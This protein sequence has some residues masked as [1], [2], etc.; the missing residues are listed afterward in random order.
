[1]RINLVLHLTNVKKRFSS[2][3]TLAFHGKTCL[4]RKCYRCEVFN[5]KFAL[6]KQL[7]DH[8]RKYHTSLQCDYCDITISSDK[9]MKR[10]V[11]LK[12]RGLPPSRARALEVD[13]LKVPKTINSFD[14]DK[15]E[16][17]FY[18]KVL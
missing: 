8:K 1:M 14:R 16:K 18:D 15:C 17:T 11:N 4:P 10:H 6:Y 3:I 7:Y 2:K 5:T 12:H 13:K 9:N